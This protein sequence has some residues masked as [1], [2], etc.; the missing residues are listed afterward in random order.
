VY[1]IQDHKGQDYQILAFFILATF[2]R[3]K[4]LHIRNIVL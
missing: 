3:W 2:Q 1:T 4:V